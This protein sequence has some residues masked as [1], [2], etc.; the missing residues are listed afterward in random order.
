MKYE[1][2]FSELM[3]AHGIGFKAL[4]VQNS[5]KCNMVYRKPYC[6]L[7]RGLLFIKRSG[8]KNMF[9]FDVVARFVKNQNLLSAII[10]NAKRC[11]VVFKKQGRFR[12][13]FVRC[14]CG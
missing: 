4:L 10:E 11:G 5:H 9:D 13:L 7:R 6:A 14:L 3:R 1:V 8:L 12:R 2:G